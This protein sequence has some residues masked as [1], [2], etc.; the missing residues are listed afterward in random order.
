[1]L[2]YNAAGQITKRTDALGNATTF[3]Y[4]A[5]GYLTAVQGPDPAANVAL[6]YDSAGRIATTTDVAGRTLTY[7]YDAADRMTGVTYPDGT[8]AKIGYTNL[9]LT[10][11]TDRLGQTTTLAYDAER[12]L[13]ST[14][15]ALGQVTK[16]GYSS[17]SKLT[18]LTDP[19][20][21]VTSW[22]RDLEGRA[23]GKTFADGTSTSIAYETT[24]SRVHQTVDAAAQTTTFAYA[25]DGSTTSIVRAGGSTSETTSFVLDPAYPRT[26]S[27]TDALGLTTWS[28]APA[29][30]L[31]AGRVAS[32]TSPVAGAPAGTND[33]VTYAYDALD[34]LVGRNVDGT[35]ESTEFDAL[36]RSTK[37]TNALDTF[38][39]AYADATPRVSGIT[40]AHGPTLS[41]GYADA[42]GD[43]LL[44]QIDATSTTQSSLARMQY[45]Y[46]A[47]DDVTS[48]G[49][50]YLGKT[51][52]A[53]GVAGGIVGPWIGRLDGQSKP[54]TKNDGASSRD[55]VLKFFAWCAPFLLVLYG[56]LRTGKRRFAALA[57]VTV[58]L[59]L[60][61][62]GGCSSNGGGPAEKLPATTYQYD[63]A[64]RVT[65]AQ[66]AG[67]SS[68]TYDPASNL[69]SITTSAQSSAGGTA[70]QSY[71]YS[72]TNGIVGATYDPNGNPT[73]LGGASYTWD[74]ANRLASATV[75]GVTSEFT[76]DGVSRLVRIV[77]KNGGAVVADR[78]FTWCE[79]D[80]CAAHDNLQSGAPVV[81]RYFDQGVVDA[82]QSLY[83]VR[84]LQ[85]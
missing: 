31:G 70:P 40:S 12:E 67:A 21:H 54:G 25:A 8:T 55:D 45:G 20:G 79:L 23:T 68:Y 43:D 32:V 41:F 56:L 10:T 62:C 14:T 42:K 66:G 64:N 83:Y 30:T 65:A 29:G 85:G 47:N 72:S 2:E 17:A 74:S 57:P 80:R 84:D 69:T 82:G 24:N 19:N 34:R 71:S 39:Y 15:D 38:A 13:T 51:V 78:A 5:K 44:A 49:Q 53:P 81:T 60:S 27:M 16:Y 22:T 61:G 58:A 76:Y 59:F 37:V 28:Y 33:T 46:D 63:A 77:E 3:T 75:G 6:T 1:K 73:A 9:D 35:A 52:T 36:G 4:D 48:F 18:S 50:S 7:A 26:A 11:L